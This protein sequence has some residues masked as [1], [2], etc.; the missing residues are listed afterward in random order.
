MLRFFISYLEWEYAVWLVVP[1]SFSWLPKHLLYAV[2]LSSAAR[3]QLE[4]VT[5]KISDLAPALQSMEVEVPLFLPAYVKSKDPSI[6]HGLK[7]AKEYHISLSRTVPIRIHQIDSIVAMLR[8]KLVSQKRWGKCQ[9]QM[10]LMWTAA[11]LSSML[12]YFT[13]SPEWRI[14]IIIFYCCLVEQVLGRVW[15]MGGFCQW[16]KD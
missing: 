10:G 4:P 15:K 2:P 3:H 1:I 12:S 16:W 13:E 8:H 9:L 14:I 7:L 11:M 6:S 5:K